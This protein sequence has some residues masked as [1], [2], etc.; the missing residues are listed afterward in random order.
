MTFVPTSGGANSFAPLQIKLPHAKRPYSHKLWRGP[1][2]AGIY[3]R[4][5]ANEIPLH[6]HDVVQLIVV[7]EKTRIRTRVGRGSKQQEVDWT[8]PGVQLIPG[9]TLHSVAWFE[10]APWAKLYY[11]NDFVSKVMGNVLLA[12]DTVTLHALQQRDSAIGMLVDATGAA[13]RGTLTDLDILTT[14]LGKRVL[15]AVA[16]RPYR[17]GKGCFEVHN[18]TKL[19]A[20]VEKF[21]TIGY[22]PLEMARIAGCSSNHFYVVFR[23][24]FGKEVREYFRERQVR[25]AQ[26]LLLLYPDL[27]LTEIAE[28]CCFGSLSTMTKWFNAVLKQP[29]SEVRRLRII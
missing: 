17:T 9:G 19:V 7:P 13:C 21:V 10:E 8:G 22:D 18:S 27:E 4:Q 20:H 11:H 29:P 14:L 12:F 26:A 16:L 5:K 15:E 24:T 25:Y 1:L 6:A 3:D 23:R 2:V 28:R